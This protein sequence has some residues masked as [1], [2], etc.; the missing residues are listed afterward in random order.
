MEPWRPEELYKGGFRAVL[1]LNGAKGVDEKALEKAGLEH[2]TVSIPITE[3]PQPEAIEIAEEVLPEAYDWV[4]R[5][6][7]EAKPVLVH[8][9]YGND[10]TGL[11]LFYFIVRHHGYSLM[12]AMRKLKTT[13]PTFL[14]A[15]GWENLAYEMTPK[16]MKKKDR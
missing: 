11:F 6:I 10:R 8:C 2:Y 15:F 5:K 1:S 4:A 3:P 12:E 14:I 16:L 9:F 7:R 13:K